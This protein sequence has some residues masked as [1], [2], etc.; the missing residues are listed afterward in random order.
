MSHSLITEQL[1]LS[2]SASKTYDAPVKYTLTVPKGW[3]E[4]RTVVDLSDIY[5]KAGQLWT[6]QT[7]RD[8]HTDFTHH[9]H[10]NSST[11]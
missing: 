2:I 3:R 6:E 9:T 5:V 1:I 10:S 11:S 8:K 4:Q 7:F